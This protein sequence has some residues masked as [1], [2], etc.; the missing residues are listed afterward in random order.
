MDIVIRCIPQWKHANLT[1]PVAPLRRLHLCNFPS[2]ERLVIASSGR[3]PASAVTEFIILGD[4]PRLSQAD[5]VALPQLTFGHHLERLTSLHFNVFDN[6]THAITNLR[7]C[8]N[9]VD[10]SCGFG[11]RG[12]DAPLPPVELNSL[13]SLIVTTE[14]MLPCVTVPLLERLHISRLS[15]NIDAAIALRS[16][17]SRSSCEIQSL[18][19]DPRQL[20]NEQFGL[21]L[22]AAN[23]TRHLKLIF[24]VAVGFSQQIQPL[25][26]ADVLPRLTHFEICDVAGRGVQY[27]SL[28]DLLSRRR[29]HTAL[30]KFELFLGTQRLG[31]SI[32]PPA[33]MDEFRALGAAG[34]RLRI[35]AREHQVGG[36]VDVTHL[37]TF[38][39]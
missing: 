38:Q 32:L 36:S 22:R 7:M 14:T 18:S 13:R 5:I 8:P 21:F 20:N 1:F 12:S 11:F 37:D 10:L 35:T 15:R 26:D 19:V 27:Q 6:A 24:S 30:E 17:V 16:L 3:V 39:G 9:L 33:V 4:A 34:M 25:E 23:F 28:L 29:Q 31:P 2:L